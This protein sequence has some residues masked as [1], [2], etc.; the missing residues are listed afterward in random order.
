MYLKEFLNYWIIQLNL[1]NIKKDGDK[2]LNKDLILKI[3]ADV[4]NNII[5]WKNSFELFTK[6]EWNSKLYS[7]NGRSTWWWKYKVTRY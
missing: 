6:N 1:Q 5:C 3:K 4:K 7:K 2:L